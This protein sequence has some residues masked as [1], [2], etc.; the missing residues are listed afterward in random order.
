MIANALQALAA[1]EPRSDAD[2][3]DTAWYQALAAAVAV[4]PKRFAVE[5]RPPTNTRSSRVSFVDQERMFYINRF[6]DGFHIGTTLRA[7]ITVEFDVAG[8]DKLAGSVRAF[9]DMLDQ[10]TARRDQILTIHNQY[11]DQIVDIATKAFG[12]REAVKVAKQLNRVE[13]ALNDART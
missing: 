8:Y 5:G 13:A 2:K 9:R 1:A 4:D 12:R 7:P 10:A 6:A 11:R 3:D